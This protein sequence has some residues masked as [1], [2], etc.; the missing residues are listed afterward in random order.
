MVKL[1]N[2]ERKAV[3]SI[4]KMHLEEVQRVQKMPDQIVELLEAEVRYED[5]IK[6]I[7]DKI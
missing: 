3:K 1:T 6:G 7:I 4:L 5:F 2:E